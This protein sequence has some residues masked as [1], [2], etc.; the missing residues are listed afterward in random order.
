MRKIPAPKASN[1]AIPFQ[2]DVTSLRL[3]A[4]APFD[5]L[6]TSRIF[7]LK[8]FDNPAGAG[9]ILR[10]DELRQIKVIL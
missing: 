8:V 2:S 5:K 3:P 7:M 4:V 1:M 9:I 6:R 10:F